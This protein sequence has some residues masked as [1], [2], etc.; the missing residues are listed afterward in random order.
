MNNY[1]VI[2]GTINKNVRRCVILTE[3]LKDINV[4]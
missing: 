4:F 2:Y 3:D 1:D